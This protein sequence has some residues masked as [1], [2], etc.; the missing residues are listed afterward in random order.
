MA[1]RVCVF[2]AGISAATLAMAAA[3]VPIFSMAEVEPHNQEG[4]LWVVVDSYVLDLSDFLRHH[5]GTSQR[6]MQKREEVGPDIS[7]NFLDHFRHTVQTFRD[8]CRE[9]EQTHQP[10]SYHYKE[11][12]SFNVTILG[13]VAIV[14]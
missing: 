2:V 3:A 10:V 8:A 1:H 14:L 11:V 13:K 6:I 4:D 12:P 5:P 7:S 9:L